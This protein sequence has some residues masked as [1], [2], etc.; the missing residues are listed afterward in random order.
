ME[1]EGFERRLIESWGSICEDREEP[2]FG[3]SC[4][5]LYRYYL[6]FVGILGIR[7]LDELTWRTVRRGGFLNFPVYGVNE[8][9]WDR[10]KVE[11]GDD[12]RQCMLFGVQIVETLLKFSVNR[13]YG[14]P[15]PIWDLL[16]RLEVAEVASAVPRSDDKVVRK[17]RSEDEGSLATKWR[18]SGPNI[19]DEQFA[20]WES[21]AWM[22]WGHPDEEF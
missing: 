2:V 8:F 3:N 14:M 17:R 7:P 10:V 11:V 13:D 6:R 20:L 9:G 4:D 1:V 15:Q 16:G 21:D 5:V 22:M 19:A 12:E 18:C